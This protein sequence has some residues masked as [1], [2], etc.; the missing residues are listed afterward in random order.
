VFDLRE[1]ESGIAEYLA[2]YN[3]L[4]IHESLDYGTPQTVH[5]GKYKAKD[6]IVGK[7][8]LKAAASCFIYQTLSTGVNLRVHFTLL[9]LEGFWKLPSI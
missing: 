8:V 2:F 7:K 5:E 6:I 1:A 3:T 9:F 4:R